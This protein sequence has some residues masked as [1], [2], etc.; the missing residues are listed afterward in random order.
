M[1]SRYFYYLFFAAL[2]VE[3]MVVGMGCNTAQWI[4]KPL[5]VLFLFA[6]FASSSHFFSPLHYSI[7]AA[8]FFSLLGDI[9]L[10]KPGAGWFMAGLASFLLAHILYIVFFL[11]LRKRQPFPFRPNSLIIGLITGYACALVMF[12]RPHIGNL[13]VPVIIYAT[14]I[15][16]MVLSAIHAGSSRQKQAGLFCV[17]GALF[18]LFSDS[19]L[20]VNKFY[21]PLPMAGI[22]VMASYGLAQFAIVKGALLYLAGENKA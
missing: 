9:F 15:A 8:L 3:L 16:G 21:R 1:L 6:W 20:A 14:A 5:L 18:F 4:T 11:R 22:A 12:L 2:L 10:L 7:A 17:G 19:L 13:L